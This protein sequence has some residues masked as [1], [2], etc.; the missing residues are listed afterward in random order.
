MTSHHTENITQTTYHCLGETTQSLPAFLS[1]FTSLTIFSFPPLDWFSSVP[2]IG[3]DCSLLISLFLLFPVYDSS[4]CHPY[5]W[6]LPMVKCL[7]NETFLD[8]SFFTTQSLSIISCAQQPCKTEYHVPY[9]LEYKCHKFR[10]ILTWHIV[11]THSF[12]I[13]WVNAH[14]F[15]LECPNSKI[16]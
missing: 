12:L 9:T 5:S 1:D 4:S 11:S 16:L 3:Q 6:L 14:L 10:D 13:I 2:Q 7:L 15:L 8:S